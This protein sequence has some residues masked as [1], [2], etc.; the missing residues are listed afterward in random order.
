MKKAR[1]IIITLSILLLGLL[2]CTDNIS[3]P[4]LN[5]DP[6]SIVQ[7]GDT[8]DAERFF[9]LEITGE[10]GKEK[11]R[12]L[13][14]L[15]NAQVIQDT[16]RIRWDGDQPSSL[17]LLL[18]DED[19][20]QFERDLSIE[21]PAQEGELSYTIILLDEN[22]VGDSLSL[23][24]TAQDPLKSLPPLIAISTSADTLSPGSKFFVS[25]LITRLA[26]DL[27][28]LEIQEND[29]RISDLSRLTLNGNP[30]DNNPYPILPKGV[31]EFS[32]SFGISAPNQPGTYTY[33]FLVKDDNGVN[34][35]VS[36]TIIVRS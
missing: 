19:K 10:K 8:V 35:E 32:G 24:L 31:E 23:N 18:S 33:G 6:S 26:V 9:T 30:L 7:N 14:I 25:C 20:D 1:P 22:Q 11:L 12:S 36:L 4:S 29:N 21:A 17:P 13:S 15:K 5:L 2:S 16:D 3:T 27:S 28:T 34:N